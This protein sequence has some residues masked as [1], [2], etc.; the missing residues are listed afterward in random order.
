MQETELPSKK[1]SFSAATLLFVLGIM[2]I[3]MTLRTPL[4]VVGPIIP[5][6][7]DGLGISNVLA[8]FLTTIP[9]LAF[10]IVSPFVAKIARTLSIERALFFALILLGAGILLRSV[11]D[12]L[13]VIIGTFLIGV[14]IAFGNVL[15]PSY[16]KLRMPLQ[17]GLM[18]GIYSVSMNISASVAAG[19]SYPLAETSVGGRGSLGFALIFVVLALLIWLPQLKFRA[20]VQ[21]PATSQKLPLY[22]LPLAWAIACMMGMQSLLFYSSSAWFPAILMSQGISASDAGWLSSLMLFAQLPMT[23]FIPILASRAKLHVP[24]TIAFSICYIVGFVGLYMEWTALAPVWMICIGLAGG[25]SFSLVM[26]LFTMRTE[27]I[28]TSAELSGFAQSTGYLLAA[29]GPITFG[30][31]HDITGSWHATCFGFIIC[32]VVL[33]VSGLYGSRNVKIE[34][35]MTSK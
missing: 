20:S 12:I 21:T 15:I 30:W 33:F 24:I 27:S 2:L 22:K 4:T 35:A 14:A 9:L 3:A 19:T 13:G 6:M 34:Q 16:L 28:Y 32:A 8:G 31:L 25:A 11:S 5:S 17:V 18:M 26:M 10:A 7:R 1:L 23:F 29:I